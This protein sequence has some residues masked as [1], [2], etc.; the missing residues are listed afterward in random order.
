MVGDAFTTAAKISRARA[1]APVAAPI[2]QPGYCR[3]ALAHLATG[4][5]PPMP[6]RRP[7]THLCAPTVAALLALLAVAL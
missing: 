2:Y 5:L 4:S 7:F 3:R 6:L 1:S